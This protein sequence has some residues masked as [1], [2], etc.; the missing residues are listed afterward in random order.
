MNRTLFTTAAALA[1]H[2]FAAGSMAPKVEAACSF[3]RASGGRA[4]IGALVTL[5]GWT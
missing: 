4:A 1:A 5:A 2:V 3:V